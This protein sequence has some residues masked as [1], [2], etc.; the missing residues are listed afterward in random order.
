MAKSKTEQLTI[1]ALF[2]ALT[3]VL[4][5]IQLPIGVIPINLAML[6]V[7]M[8][9]TI[10][11]WKLGAVSQ[12]VY[13]LLGAVGLPV[14][15]GFSGGIGII[16]GPTGGYIIGYVVAALVIGLITE[17]VPGNRY[18]ITAIAIFAG[19]IVCYAL[20]TAWF[21][22]VQKSTLSIAMKYCVL[23]FIPGE[24]AKMAIAVVASVRLKKILKI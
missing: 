20:G 21:I 2:A 9:G 18:L 23:P 8:T 1:T 19:I 7:F 12:I 5:Q 3:S 11:G 17:K 4:S 15:A 6:S 14:F 24:I 10:L 13:V 22:Y 16:K